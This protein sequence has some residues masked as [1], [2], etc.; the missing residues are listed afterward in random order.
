MSV[1]IR[2]ATESD[3]EQLGALFVEEL[4]FHAGLLPDLYQ[5]ADP[6][7][8]YEWFGRIITNDDQVIFV[9]ELDQEIVGLVQLTLRSNPADPIYQPRRYVHV[10]DLAVTKRYYRRGIGRLLMTKAREWAQSKGASEIE[11]NVW[12]LNERAISFYE[13]LE[14]QTIRRTMKLIL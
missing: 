5:V 14:Y 2:Q 11:L 4:T 6:I 12:E 9:A 7:M 8:T 1:T 13:E 3:F 10:N